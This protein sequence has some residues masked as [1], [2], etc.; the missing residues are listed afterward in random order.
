MDESLKDAINEL[1]KHPD[2]AKAMYNLVINQG[3]L[4]TPIRQGAWT[5][6]QVFHHIADSHLNSYIRIKL[7]LTENN[8]TIKAYHEPSWAELEDV[9]RVSP[10]VSLNLLD[11]IHKRL[12]AIVENLQADELNR[13][14]NH[15]EAGELTIRQY[16]S[17]IANHGRSHLEGIQLM[18]NTL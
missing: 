9:F 16:I 3:V 14:F 18:L 15:P 4:E 8:P 11:S 2:K 17:S 5:C 13:K 6:R 7:A 10:E 1:T 12:L